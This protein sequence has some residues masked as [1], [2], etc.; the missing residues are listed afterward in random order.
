MIF[1]REDEKKKHSYWLQIFP[2]NLKIQRKL[3]EIHWLRISLQY[4]FPFYYL[5]PIKCVDHKKNFIQNFFDRLLDMR[6]VPTSESY[7]VF[8]DD[9]W[10]KKTKL[11]VALDQKLVLEKFQENY[12]MSQNNQTLSKS[13]HSYDSFLEQKLGEF[14]THCSNPNYYTQLFRNLDSYCSSNSKLFSQLKHL[15]YDLTNS[16]SEVAQ[17]IDRITQ[18][19]GQFLK[20]T[21]EAYKLLGVKQEQQVSKVCQSLGRGFMQWSA[22]IQK[23]KQLITDRLAGFFHFKKREYTSFLDLIRN[24]QD[25]TKQTQ[26]TTQD[27]LKKKER[28]F[29]G[30]KITEWE[31]P[32]MNNVDV[33]QALE[34]FQVAEQ[35][36][37]PKETKQ[38]QLLVEMDRFLNKHLLFEFFN[39]DQLSQ[40]YIEDTIA[41]FSK[42]YKE[43][44]QNPQLLWNLFERSEVDVSQMDWSSTFLWQ[45]NIADM[46]K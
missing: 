10:L 9:E 21:Q 7:R 35:H 37:L 12:L 3:K 39:F 26:K 38:Q 36:M 34:N 40:F 43:D 46:F 14:Q 4:E 27:L 42:E 41:Q 44:F 28:L 11:G 18:V 25:L 15:C 23:T 8:L 20:E 24:K 2:Q 22:H 16:L 6:F 19:Y 17:K 32:D 33:K 31:I 13:E 29:N 1:L 45:S 5:P 30:K